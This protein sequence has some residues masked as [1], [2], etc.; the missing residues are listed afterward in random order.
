[1]SDLA[2][3][4]EAE[5][6]QDRQQHEFEVRRR[7]AA[8]RLWHVAQAE[9]AVTEDHVLFGRVVVDRCGP[10]IEA[11]RALQLDVETIAALTPERSHFTKPWMAPVVAR[12]RDSFLELM[13]DGV[14]ALETV[15]RR[16]AED[17]KLLAARRDPEKSRQLKALPEK[18]HYWVTRY[19]SGRPPGA[20]AW[21][22]HYYSALAQ[23][24]GR[25]DGTYRD[26]ISRDEQ[27]VLI[28]ML[29]LGLF[30][31]EF[32]KGRVIAK[33]AGLGP[34]KAKKVIANLGKRRLVVSHVRG[35]SLT[36]DGRRVAKRQ[37]Q[38]RE[39]GNH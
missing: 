21:C 20:S 32:L 6:T 30:E 15:A 34:S 14:G 28:T 11:L 4:L 2:R 26:R 8:G 27:K 33:K 13:D 9:L 12:T 38:F 18:L 1:M 25:W 10:A 17:H 37:E 31:G 39:S 19:D 22:L 29:D 23:A 35:S 5:Q 3:A 7:R 24:V 16:F 36:P